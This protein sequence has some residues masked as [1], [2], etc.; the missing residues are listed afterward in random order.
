[1][2]KIQ[3]VLLWLGGVFTE[4]IPEITVRQLYDQPITKLD[5]PTRLQLRSL[6]EELTLGRIT[7]QEF[8][9]RMVAAASKPEGGRSAMTAA[10]LET[11]IREGLTF[12]RGALDAIQELPDRYPLWL[13]CDYPLDWARSFA[14]RN[15]LWAQFPQERW[16][17]PAACRLAR[18]VPDIFY[19]LARQA[20]Q[21]LEACLLV[22]VDS[23]RDVEAVR[24]G[25]SSTFYI[26]LPRL[27]REFVMR[28]MLA[29]TQSF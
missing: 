24:H 22:D 19:E 7:G 27:R 3:T 17:L 9:Q 29:S 15:N 23:A 12:K 28:N 4:T 16:I 25:M 20:G 13:V 18:I 14:D 26:D 1:M 21:P 8:C 10:E 6:A 2:P 5:V 11:G